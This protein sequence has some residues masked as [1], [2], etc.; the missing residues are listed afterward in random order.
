MRI[1]LFVIGT[2]LSLA[3]LAAAAEG[4]KSPVSKAASEKKAEL[5]KSPG[6][7]IAKDPD[8]GLRA[9]TA[10]EAAALGT[11]PQLSAV[12]AS[13]EPQVQT[14]SNGSIMMV[15]DPAVHNIYSVVTKGPDGKVN[16]ECR[17]GHKAA[18]G[19]VQSGVASTHTH[20]E[21]TNEK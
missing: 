21:D 18:V 7:V 17:T 9:P 11:A 4:V 6:M 2:A 14:L 3:C 19:T 13:S 16:L 20:R 5:R 15:L 12:A 10:E 1:K 8:G